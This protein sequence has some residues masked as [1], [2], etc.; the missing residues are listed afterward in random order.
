MICHCYFRRCAKADDKQTTI[1]SLD[2]TD[3]KVMEGG[4]NAVGC[5][6]LRSGCG[7]DLDLDV[8]AEGSTLD[9]LLE[10]PIDV[11]PQTTAS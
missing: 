10:G 4:F 6:F 1:S 8:V 3:I 9:P 7:A 11:R 5:R 2:E